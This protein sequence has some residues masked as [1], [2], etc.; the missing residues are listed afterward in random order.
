MKKLVKFVLYFVS[1]ITLLHVITAWKDKD[2]LRENIIRLHV[3]GNSNT[4]EDQN[5]KLQV[6]DAVVAYLTPT[7]EECSDQDAA[8]LFLQENLDTIKEI[9]DNVLRNIGSNDRTVVSI[10][11]E[12]F[13][14]R[15]YNSFSLPSG[16]YQALRI[17]IGKAEGRNWW[18]VAFPGLCLP[19]T[20]QEFVDAAVS[21][22]FQED[23]ANTLSQE[24]GLELRFYLLD[25]LGRLENLFFSLQD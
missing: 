4:E 1:I 6:K 10:S 17:Q 20:S 16:I 15:H 2:F 21:S 14:T 13:D 12:P 19:S 8:K 25:T 23:L 3:V 5:I 9:A 11:E 24:G 7:L 22:G 18:C